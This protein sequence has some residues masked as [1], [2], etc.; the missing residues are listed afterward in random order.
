MWKERPDGSTFDLRENPCE[1]FES[2]N[3]STPWDDLHL[4][5][6]SGYAMWNYVSAP[7]YFASPE[8]AP[9]EIDNDLED[10]IAAKWRVLE[11]TYPDDVHTH[12]KAQ[13]YYSDAKFVLRRLDYTADVTGGLPVAHYFFRSPK[14]RRAAIAHV[15]SRCS[16]SRGY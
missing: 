9:V 16:G 2:H 10:P 14:G 13:K 6:F 7:F 12:C 1:A 3:I 4:L 8:I 5:Y 11:V 15:A